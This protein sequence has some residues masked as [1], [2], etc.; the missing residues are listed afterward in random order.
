MGEGITDEE[1]ID[2]LWNV[3]KPF[4]DAVTY[5]AAN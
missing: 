3:N 4:T 2:T 1:L 5:V